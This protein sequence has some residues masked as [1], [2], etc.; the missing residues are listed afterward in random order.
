M[1]DA[2]YSMGLDHSFSALHFSLVD[3]SWFYW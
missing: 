2:L 3:L 1:I